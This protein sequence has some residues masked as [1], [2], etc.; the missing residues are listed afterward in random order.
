MFKKRGLWQFYQPLRSGGVKQRSCETA[1][2][3]HARKMERLVLRLADDHRWPVLEALG[4]TVGGRKITVPILYALSQQD[5]ELRD[6]EGA[7]ASKG[8][9]PHIEGWIAD[10]LATGKTPFTAGVY[11]RRLRH[12]LAMVE[13]E[14]GRPAGSADLTPAYA[15]QWIAEL[16][17]KGIGGRPM[18]TASRRS[19]FYVL[20]SFIRYLIEL[21]TL[22]RDPLA[23]VKAPKKGPRRVRYESEANDRRIVEA[24]PSLALRALFAF[25]HATGAEVTPAIE[26]HARDFDLDRVGDWARCTVRGTKTAKR[27]RH[28]V[29]IEPWALE[30]LR[31]HLRTFLPNARP[32]AGITRHMAHHHHQATCAALGIEDYT[33]RDARHSWAVRA[34]TLRGESWEEI[35]DQLGNSPWIVSTTYAVFK[36]PTQMQPVD[37]HA[38]SM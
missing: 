29:R 1:D 19:A 32:W 20:K 10:V 11:E 33:L 26:A 4:A 5:P 21:G 24:A 7:L 14:S 18:Q 13:R 30:I 35:A 31:S 38:A 9:A 27:H 28:F 17:R 22:D 16:T 12:F 8:L 6:F 15:K 36:R 3:Q 34:R 25:I 37:T 2:T 23:Q